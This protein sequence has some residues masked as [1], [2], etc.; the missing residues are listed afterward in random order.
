M[1]TTNSGDGE[2]VYSSVINGETYQNFAIQL[3]GSADVGVTFKV[4][5][6][7]IEDATVPT[8][9]DDAPSTDWYD[10]S[11]DVLGGASTTLDAGASEI[12]WIDTDFVFYA[13]IV[14]AVP[15]DA[16]NT[17]DVYVRK[18]Y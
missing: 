7:L 18:A 5:A 11:T 10:C 17:A 13:M 15:D 8:Q 2:E 6:T 1:D 3:Q 16:T 14:Q 12:H 4:F 9:W